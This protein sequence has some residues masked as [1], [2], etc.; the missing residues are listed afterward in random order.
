MKTNKELSVICI[1]GHKRYSHAGEPGQAGG[2]RFGQCSSCD[3]SAFTAGSPPTDPIIQEWLYAREVM[4]RLGFTPDELFFVVSTSGKILDRDTGVVTDHGG[5]IIAL[6]LRAQGKEFSWTIGATKLLAREIESAY[7]KACDD[8]NGAP[9]DL[10]AQDAAFRSS[11]SYEMAMD[12]MLAL[13]S[14]GFSFVEPS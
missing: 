5:P 10:P 9:V 12:L 1:C 2:V 4:R 14:R 6:V 7:R 13:K 8:W 11:K 3:C